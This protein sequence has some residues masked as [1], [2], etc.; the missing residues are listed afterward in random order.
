MD[1]FK[2]V[3][4]CNFQANACLVRLVIFTVAQTFLALSLIIFHITS[5]DQLEIGCN[6][7]TAWILGG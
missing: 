4:K 5:Y 2:L 1:A 7:V 3:K 6:G